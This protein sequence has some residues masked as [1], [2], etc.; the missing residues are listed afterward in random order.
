M[1]KNRKRFGVGTN[2]AWYTT[3]LREYSEERTSSNRRKQRVVWK[4]PFF[5]R[6]EK[7]LERC[8]SKP[9]HEKHPTYKGCTVCEEWLTFSNFRRW[10]EN[11]D[12]EGK[13]LDK[14]LLQKGNKVYSPETC[15]FIKGV[16]NRFINSC[17]GSRGKYLIGC[18]SFNKT[19]SKFVAECQNPFSPEN[20]SDGYIGEYITELEAHLAWKKRKHEYACQLADSEYVTDNRV[21]R[22]LVTTYKNYSILEDHIK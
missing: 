21:Y 18:T 3:E 8:Y 10:M 19:N 5:R 1:N 11:Q 2:D 22:V 6:W 13:D 9:L 17:S 20:S 7:M 14:D 15:I 12:W 16:V 4:C